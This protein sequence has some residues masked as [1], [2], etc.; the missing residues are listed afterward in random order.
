MMYFLFGHK[1]VCLTCSVLIAVDYLQ[2][3]LIYVR[4]SASELMHMEL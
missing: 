3:V 1:F 2:L 4:I